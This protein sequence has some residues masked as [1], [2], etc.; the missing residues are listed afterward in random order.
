MFDLLAVTLF[1]VFLIAGAALLIGYIAGYFS[2][3]DKKPNHVLIEGKLTKTWKVVGNT[4]AD[5]RYT[6]TADG[7]ACPGAT[8]EFKFGRQTPVQLTAGGALTSSGLY[9]TTTT[10][11]DG[12]G[13]ASCTVTANGKGPG[14]LT[15]VLS[16]GNL[17]GAD[18]VVK[19]ECDDAAPSSQ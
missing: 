7:K 8:V 19:F 13:V 4:D 11:T 2:G 14:E 18:P 15:T 6:V 3:K 12:S 16:F 5:F 9:L 1:Y 10:T 17:T